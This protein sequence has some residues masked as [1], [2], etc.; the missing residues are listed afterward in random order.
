MWPTDLKKRTPLDYQQMLLAC[1]MR[2]A[3]SEDPE[4]DQGRFICP[5]K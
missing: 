2:L 5:R 3:L 1:N 4:K